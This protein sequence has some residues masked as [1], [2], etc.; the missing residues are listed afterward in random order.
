MF[1]FTFPNPSIT[2][3]ILSMPALLAVMETTHIFSLLLN[4]LNLA[5]FTLEFAFLKV[6]FVDSFFAGIGFDDRHLAVAFDVVVE[7]WALVDQVALGS[8]KFALTLLAAFDELSLIETAIREHVLAL[9]MRQ[10]LHPLSHIERLIRHDE[11]PLP[12]RCHLPFISFLPNCPLKRTSILKCHHHILPVIYLPILKRCHHLRVIEL[13]PQSSLAWELFCHTWDVPLEI[14]PWLEIERALF[15]RLEVGRDW[16]LV[17]G[18]LWFLV[19]D[20]GFGLVMV[21]VRGDDGALL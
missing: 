4:V 19:V 21:G 7:K 2:I 17:V 6:A 11:L 5:V 1:P 20:R 12:W 15:Y 3:V 9:P 14:N 8:G 18:Q 10:V 13:E 16:L